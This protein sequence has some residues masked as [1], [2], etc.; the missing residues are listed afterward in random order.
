ML[1][2]D[3]EYENDY[4]WLKWNGLTILKQNQKLQDYLAKLKQNTKE[5]VIND[6][7]LR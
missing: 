1:L 4:F 7:L 6:G 2:S 5:I 3:P